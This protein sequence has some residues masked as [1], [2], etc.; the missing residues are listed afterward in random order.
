MMTVETIE[1]TE[2]VRETAWIHEMCQSETS[3]KF[4]RI[5][6]FNVHF[7]EKK[8]VFISIL[9]NRCCR[10]TVLRSTYDL[11]SILSIQNVF[12][13]KKAISIWCINLINNNSMF[14]RRTFI[15]HQ[16]HAQS[17][18]SRRHQVGA[19]SHHSR[20]FRVHSRP[21]VQIVEFV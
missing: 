6:H 18:V 15:N 21:Q 3:L 16:P 10:H 19:S 20:F 11:N 1:R 12:T 14:I 7:I 8:S 17:I 2:L 9:I 4:M 5:I 13:T